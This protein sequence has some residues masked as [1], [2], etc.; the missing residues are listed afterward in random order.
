ME[1][2]PVAAARGHLETAWIRDLTES[3]GSRNAHPNPAPAEPKRCGL[4]RSDHKTRKQN[5]KSCFD[6]VGA[7]GAD[8][9]RIINCGFGSCGNCGFDRIINCGFVTVV[10]HGQRLPMTVWVSFSSSS[11][12]RILMPASIHSNKVRA[13]SVPSIAKQ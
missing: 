4:C 9:D 1:L 2:D 3:S 13:S 12:S 5:Y 11:M 6:I 7:S 10:L 8:F